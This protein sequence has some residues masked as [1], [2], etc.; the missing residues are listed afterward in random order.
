MSGQKPR[1][2]RAVVHAVDHGVLK[3]DA[4]TG[5]LIVG[6]ARPDQL[7][8]APPVI[9]GHDA[10][11]CLIVRRVQRDRQ[12]ELKIPFGKLFKSL[13]QPAGGKRD[14]AHADVHALRVVYQLQKAHDVVEV[15]QRL[16]DAHEDD[17][18]DFFAGIKLGKQHLV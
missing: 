10:G 5:F 16:P 7:L 15:I 12:R 2:L 17:V 1:L 4:P 13:D 6:F 14:V 18:G 8:H 3:G 11:S 9:G